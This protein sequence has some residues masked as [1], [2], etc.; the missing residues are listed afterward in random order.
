MD[1]P[2]QNEEWGCKWMYTRI[3]GDDASWSIMASWEIFELNWAS[4]WEKTSRNTRPGKLTV[5]Y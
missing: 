4:E 2:I 5:C 3:F 1:L